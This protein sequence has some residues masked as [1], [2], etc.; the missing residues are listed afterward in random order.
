[1][2]KTILASSET[3][4]DLSSRREDRNADGAIDN[5]V[6]AASNIAASVAHGVN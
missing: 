5:V 3:N 1:M 2:N 6:T 4:N